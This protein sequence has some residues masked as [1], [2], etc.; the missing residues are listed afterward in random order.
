MDR[1]SF[2]RIRSRRPTLPPPL[3]RREP[4]AFTGRRAAGSRLLPATKLGGR[5]TGRPLEQPRREKG[6]RRKEPR[7]S[8]R[9]AE[10]PRSALKSGV[11]CSCLLFF[12]SSF[13]L[14]ARSVAS[15]RP[16][17]CS[18]ASS[19]HGRT[20]KS[21]VERLTVLS[22]PLDL[23]GELHAD[24]H[25]PRGI[26]E[27]AVESARRRCRRQPY[28]NRV[29]RPP[30][31]DFGA[32]TR[33]R[34]PTLTRRTATRSDSRPG[35]TARTGRFSRLRRQECSAMLARPPR[36]TGWRMGQ[37]AARK[38]LALT[39]WSDTQPSGLVRQWTVPARMR[40]EQPQ[41]SLAGHRP[42]H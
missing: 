4:R 26:D 22:L 38:A 28:I 41:G 15:H 10:P 21:N 17:D 32:I 23:P 2:G 30:H 42:A 1:N 24:Q 33:I 20:S 9:V 36:R 6:E 8:V 12:P 16:R 3:D 35:R 5:S 18:P 11:S 31:P 39:E 29:W 19:V 34:H 13:D 7:N 37:L 40:A 25:V 27:L 14:P